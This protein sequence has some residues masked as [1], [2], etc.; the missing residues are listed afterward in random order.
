MDS[1]SDSPFNYSW[2]SFPKMRVLKRRT[3]PG[4]KGRVE[5]EILGESMFKCFRDKI[6]ITHLNRLSG[7]IGCFLLFSNQTK[8]LTLPFLRIALVVCIQVIDKI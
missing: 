7:I 2:P 4:N 8:H 3:K 5:R 6:L 1:D